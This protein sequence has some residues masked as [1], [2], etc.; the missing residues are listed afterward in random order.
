LPVGVDDQRVSEARLSFGDADAT[1]PPAPVTRPAATFPPPTS[2]PTAGGGGGGAVGDRRGSTH[3]HDARPA[4]HRRAGSVISQPPQRHHVG[5]ARGC[6]V[7]GT[8]SCARA[9]DGHIGGLAGVQAAAP[10]LAVML[11]LA[12][13]DR[14]QRP[15]PPTLEAMLE[16][17]R[18]VVAPP[19]LEAMLEAERL[20]SLEQYHHEHPCE[21]DRTHM[22]SL[23]PTRSS[24]YDPLAV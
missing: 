5:R 1:P 16:A 11:E 20:Q 2:H 6:S 24:T 7:E 17:E 4:I 10:T 19:T 13:R 12:E 3:R 23:D 22:P 21:V 8:L 15:A 14:Q 18:Q 9:S